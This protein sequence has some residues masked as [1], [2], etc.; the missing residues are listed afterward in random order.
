MIDITDHN[1]YNY[2]RKPIKKIF[3]RNINRF[4][5]Y[6]LLTDFE[7]VEFK[8]VG[9]YINSEDE[10][11]LPFTIDDV[12]IFANTISKNIYLFHRKRTTNKKYYKLLDILENKYDYQ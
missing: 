3:K 8:E 11:F 7:L 1:N 4:D 6:Y 2:L 12:T 9:I 5:K 10:P